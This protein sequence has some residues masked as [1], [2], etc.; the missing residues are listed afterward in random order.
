MVVLQGKKSK[1]QNENLI[2]VFLLCCFSPSYI[3][4]ILN[5]YHEHLLGCDITFSTSYI[6]CTTHPKWSCLS[7]SQITRKTAQCVLLLLH[8]S[9]R[10]L[11][12]VIKRHLSVWSN[13]SHS[14]NQDAHKEIRRRAGEPITQQFLVIMQQLCHT[15]LFCSVCPRFCLFIVL[16][17]LL[18]P[19]IVLHP[20]LFGI[21]TQSYALYYMLLSAPGEHIQ[22]I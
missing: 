11:Q 7:S 6:V 4:R 1:R 18:C 17:T 10:G 14:A 9:Q 3:S 16:H 8:S 15:K 2:P 5:G 19:C 20:T 12:L 22:A 13:N 21:F